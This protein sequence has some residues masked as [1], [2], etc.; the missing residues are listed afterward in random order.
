MSSNEDTEFQKIMRSP[1]ISLEEWNRAGSKWTMDNPEACE[2]IEMAHN[3]AQFFEDEMGYTRRMV[4][5]G[6]LEATLQL[7]FRRRDQRYIER[8]EEQRS[9]HLWALKRLKMEMDVTTTPEEQKAYESKL[10]ERPL[11]LF[12][13]ENFGAKDDKKTR[14]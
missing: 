7:A 4:C 10:G 1:A 2:V 14:Q 11:W 6:L 9:F 3:L 5:E 8:P 12:D 13:S